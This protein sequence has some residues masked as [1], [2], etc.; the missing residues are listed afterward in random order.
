[1][2]KGQ[3]VVGPL[4]VAVTGKHHDEDDEIDPTKGIHK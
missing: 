3:G 4:V 2:P 1:M